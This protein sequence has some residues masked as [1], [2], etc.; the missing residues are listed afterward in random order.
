M[1]LSFES[2]SSLSNRRPN[3]VRFHFV[4]PETMEIGGFYRVA[5]EKRGAREDGMKGK[6]EVLTSGTDGGTRMGWNGRKKV[7]HLNLDLFH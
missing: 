6:E 4:T 5:G 3:L 7:L 2:F 1:L